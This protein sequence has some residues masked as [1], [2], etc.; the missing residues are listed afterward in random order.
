MFHEQHLLNPT[1]C[2]YDPVFSLHTDQPG[3]IN[4]R[5][6]F[7]SLR[8]PTG[9][10]W[11]VK[12]LG[13]WEHWEYLMR[14]SWFEEAYNGWVRELKTVLKM[15]ALQKI[16]EIARSGSVQAFP[17]AKYLASAEW[18]KAVRTRGAPSKEE[19]QG[20]LRNAVK[21]LTVL[22]EDAQRMG[23]TIIQGGKK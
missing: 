16:D 21:E 5:K 9:Y 7:L 8:D 2:A 11:A 18:E 3:L 13:S 12:Y 6:T 22:E 17:A 4:C 14:S 1:Q 23:L 20:E 19:L 15:E 10:L